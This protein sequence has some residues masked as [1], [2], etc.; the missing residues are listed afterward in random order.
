MASPILPLFLLLVAQDPAPEVPQEAPAEVQPAAASAEE[1]A[2]APVEAPAE[3]PRLTPLPEGIAAR[4]GEL[5]VPFERLDELLTT[6]HGKRAEGLD[7]L[8]R[9]LSTTLLRELAEAEGVAISS[10]MLNAR[11]AELDAR[12]K[13]EGVEGGLARQLE[14]G[15]VDPDLF[16]EMLA[17]SMAQEELTRRA[18]GMPEGEHPTAGQQNTWLDAILAERGVESFIEPFP[19]DPAAVVARAGET[20]VTLADFHGRMR[21]ELPRQLI[22]QACTQ[23][24]LLVA[25]EERAGAVD[26]AEW[27]AAVQKELDAR[28]AKHAADPSRQGISYEALLD[29]QGLSLGIMARDPAVEV[30]A[31]TTVLG[32]RKAAESAPADLPAE[33]TFEERVQAGLIALYE[34]EPD[35]FDGYYGER[36]HV[37]ACMQRASE[38][39]N[40]L[41]PRSIEQS[42]GFFEK[43]A[44][45][46]ADEEGFVAVVGEISD[47][48]GMKQSGG[49]LGWFGKSD[50]RLPENLRLLAFDHWAAKGA[51]GVAGPIQVNGGVA[52]LW[53][54]AHQPAPEWE[55]MAEHVLREHQGRIL[56]EVT[57]RGGIQVYLDPPPVFEEAGP[58]APEGAGAPEAPGG[59]GAT[60]D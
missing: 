21:M 28:R 14:V 57:P 12:M 52:I 37:R 49:E 19:E 32:R 27:E 33:A 31:L 34:A 1:P 10:D 16:R 59:A 48:P 50:Q 58:G 29:A 35:F 18:L 22:E 8:N 38:T 15:D 11:I 6:R 23:L 42:M 2:E 3:P 47:D 25:L 55:V 24:V 26:P 36:L 30:T 53:V 9:L 44:P 4:A 54:G 45:S 60:T 43:L 5:L 56:G 7:V 39:P 13:A 46:I 40:E 20:V 17:L 41:V 51:P